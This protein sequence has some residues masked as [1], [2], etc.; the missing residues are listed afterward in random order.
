MTDTAALIERLAQHR[1]IGS[2]PVEELAWLAEHGSVRVFVRGELVFARNHV[3]DALNIVLS[4]HFAIRV[5]R[6]A[7]PRKV[8]EWRAG[9]VSGLL[10]YSRMGLPPGDSVA[11]EPCETLEVNAKHFPELT[12]RC[13]NVTAILVHVMLDRA[14]QFV[15]ADLHDEKMISLGRLSAGLAHE[16]NNPASA[17]V[18]SAKLLADG[19]AAMDAAGDAFAAAAPSASTRQAVHGLRELCL[20]S[21]SVFRSPIERS[22]REDAI[23]DWLGDHG[24]DTSLA[25]TLA[26]SAVTI[27]ALDQF[28]AP[29]A[30]DALET[31]LRWI[32]A[33]CAARA[34][35]AEVESATSRIYDLVAAVK[36]FTYMGRSP[37]PEVVDLRQGLQDTLT[38]LGAKSRAKS[39]AVSLEVAADLPKV[40]S[41]G[42]EL[43]QVWVNL[44]DNALDAVGPSG[45]VSVS[46]VQELGSVVVRIIDD[47]PGIPPELRDQI[48]DPFYTTKPVGQ[49]TGLGL[50]IAL[51]LV[52]R[53]DGE[54]DVDSHPGRTEFRVTLPPASRTSGAFGAPGMPV[55]PPS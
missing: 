37:T 5:D 16:L 47:G 7:G 18:R 36:R 9:D 33:G 28:T 43:N 21:P 29:L 45:H 15:S 31:P 13:P 32:A 30:P 50:D 25:A 39:V 19:L 49:G 23:S 41:F 54:I 4:G 10:P 34:L 3:A 52:R 38:V 1:T 11:S 42:G 48:F 8:L 6:G 35:G 44:I 14:R 51:R 22:D 24:V 55:A 17:A 26:E 27:E 20:A 2:A 40:R 53:H 12:R 46:A